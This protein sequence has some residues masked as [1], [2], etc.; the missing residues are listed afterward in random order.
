MRCRW[1]HLRALDISPDIDVENSHSATTETTTYHDKASKS[2]QKWLDNDRQHR[3]TG[4]SHRQSTSIRC[5]FRSC[6][7]RICE[8]Y[9]CSC[10]TSEAIVLESFACQRYV[11]DRTYGPGCPNQNRA[12]SKT[13]KRLHNGFQ[14][15]AN[16]QHA[17]SLS[18]WLTD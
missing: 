12:A 11:T 10:S 8:S 4:Q 15:K 13:P 7:T 5:Y 14:S 9:C 18:D 1:S 6:E 17:V 2:T 3:Q 16:L